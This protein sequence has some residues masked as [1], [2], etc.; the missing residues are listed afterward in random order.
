MSTRDGAAVIAQLNC[1]TGAGQYIK[2]QNGSV[3]IDL[4]DGLPPVAGQNVARLF[5]L[6]DRFSWLQANC[7]VVQM[8]PRRDHL[9]QE[10]SD[11]LFGIRV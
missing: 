3:Q 4:T 7:S 1:A 6:V 11:A 10:M 9:L 2:A 8:D 5:V